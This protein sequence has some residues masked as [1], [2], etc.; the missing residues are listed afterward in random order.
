M[1]TTL[2]RSEEK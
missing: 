2:V 1:K